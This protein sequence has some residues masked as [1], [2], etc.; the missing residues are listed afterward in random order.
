MNWNNLS[1]IILGLTAFVSAF[2]VALWISLVIWTFRDM[3]ARTRDAF[4]QLLAALMVLVLGP[5]GALLYLLLR[6]RESL[7]EKYER[8][9]EEEALLQDI[10][11]RTICPACKQPIEADF[12]LCPVCHTKLRQSCM[13]CKRLIH[14]RWSMC[15]YCGKEQKAIPGV[16]RA[17]RVTLLDLEREE[18]LTVEAAPAPA[19]LAEPVFARPLGIDDTIGG[20]R[21][22]EPT[23]E[24]NNPTSLPEPEWEELEIEDFDAFLEPSSDDGEEIGP[25]ESQGSTE[26]SGASAATQDTSSGEDERRARNLLS[27]LFKQS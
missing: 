12:V 8:S 10:E 6:P 21:A 27:S 16:E 19:A 18:A 17:G 7:T 25:E 26:A 13:H 3:R 15:P 11:D 5:L 4:A 22:I 9:L 24:R 2:V 1:L 23:L 20:K 14:P